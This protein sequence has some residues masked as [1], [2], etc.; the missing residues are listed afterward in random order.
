[1]T[2]FLP[3]T[4]ACLNVYLQLTGNLEFLRA[5]PAYVFNLGHRT[6]A[7]AYMSQ[8]KVPIRMLLSTFVTRIIV[9]RVVLSDVDV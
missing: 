6:R 7:L 2:H 9:V 4:G 8:V 1:M 3:F 5:M